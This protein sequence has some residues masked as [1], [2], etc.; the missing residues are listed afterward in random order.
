MR[1]NLCY[2]ICRPRLPFSPFHS[3][4]AAVTFV[5]HSEQLSHRHTLQNGKLQHWENFIV[6]SDKG[7]FSFSSERTKDPRCQGC[8]RTDAPEWYSCF[9]SPPVS[10]GPI[11]QYEPGEKLARNRDKYRSLFGSICSDRYKSRILSCWGQLAN[12]HI[13]VMSDAG[14]SDDMWPPINQPHNVSPHPWFQIKDF[15]F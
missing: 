10:S 9:F 11:S 1:V 2:L 15:F 4:L 6:G 12:L 3:L 13:F 8:L 5:L 14:R 7:L